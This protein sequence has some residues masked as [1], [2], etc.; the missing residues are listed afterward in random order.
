ML[1]IAEMDFF[2][3]SVGYAHA[4][5]KPIISEQIRTLV[6]SDYSGEIF[7]LKTHQADETH[8]L[9]RHVNKHM[10]A[11][12]KSLVLHSYRHFYFARALRTLESNDGESKR[13]VKKM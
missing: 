10:N 1:R 7:V 11:C 2:F 8:Y 9:R 5:T 12:S 4:W 13:I 3:Y 6:Q